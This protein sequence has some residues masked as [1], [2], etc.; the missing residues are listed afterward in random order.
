MEPRALAVSPSGNSVYVAIFRSSNA[1]TLI[2][3]GDRRSL[4][5]NVAGGNAAGPLTGTPVFTAGPYGGT[6]PARRI[7]RA[8]M[9]DPP[10]AQE[11][12]ELGHHIV[13]R[14]SNCFVDIQ[15]SVA[16]GA[17]TIGVN[18]RRHASR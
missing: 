18:T 11:T 7:K 2:S 16:D 1:T 10:E 17:D 4:I 14:P 12:P 9:A 6:N 13:R 3:G 15:H 8:C 5:P